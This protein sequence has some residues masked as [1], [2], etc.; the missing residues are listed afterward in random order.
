MAISVNVINP[1]LAD[2]LLFIFRPFT[3]LDPAS[4]ERG[5][6]FE[7]IELILEVMNYLH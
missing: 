7:T 3:L 2:R 6:E 5:I 4:Q 1:K